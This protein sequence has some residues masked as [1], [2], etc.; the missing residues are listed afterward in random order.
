MPYVAEKVLDIIQKRFSKAGLFYGLEKP[1]FGL[2][3]IKDE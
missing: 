1:R 3:D 2:T